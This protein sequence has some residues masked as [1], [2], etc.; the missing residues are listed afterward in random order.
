MPRDCAA[1][2]LDPAKDE[3]IRAFIE[4]RKAPPMPD[5]TN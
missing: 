3:A 4:E 1:L 5:A 2:T